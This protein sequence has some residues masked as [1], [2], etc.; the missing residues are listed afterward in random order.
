MNVDEVSKRAIA[1]EHV[2]STDVAGLLS[3]CQGGLIFALK[4]ILSL[5][6]PGKLATLPT[7]T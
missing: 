4:D 6:G 7:F 5:L 1:V 3:F 2:E